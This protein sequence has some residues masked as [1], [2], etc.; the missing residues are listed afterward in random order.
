[1]AVDQTDPAN[2]VVYS[3]DDYSGLG[4]T[5]ARS[6]GSRAARAHPPALP[7][8]LGFM[9]NNCPTPTATA[10]PGAP[11]NVFG[12]ASNNAVTVN[13]S[14]AQSNQPVTSYTV[15][16]FA[17]GA[18]VSSVSVV[19]GVAVIPGIAS[20]FPPTSVLIS[21]LTNLTSYTFT[22]SATNASGTSP[23]S[24]P[25]APVIP[26]GI[27]PPAAPGT[28]VAIA[29]DTQASVTFTVAPPPQGAPITSYLVT[30]NPGG[31][32]ASIPPPASG[33]TATA[34]VGGLT[35]GVTYT[36]SAHAN[37]GTVGK[38]RAYE[39][40]PSNPVTPLAAHV[41]VLNVAINGP[42]SSASRRRR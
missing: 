3:S 41:P 27:A 4:L 34:L 6:C 20:P 1:M 18:A 29:G 33:N 21:G 35:N 15:T 30:S 22:V 17:G 16:T 10:A 37:N 9:P 26:P 23:D 5:G 19:P 25:S 39:S 2:V 32:T 40:G 42:S 28:P 14:P 13:W 24:A 36:F 8:A 12:V 38:N 31:I 11:V 7:P